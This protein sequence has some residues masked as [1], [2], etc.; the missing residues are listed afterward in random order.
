MKPDSPTEGIRI[1]AQRLPDARPGPAP[2]TD[3]GGDGARRATALGLALAGPV[4]LVG[5]SGMQSALS[6]ASGDARMVATL[7]WW[8]F[9]VATFVLVVSLGLLAVAVGLRRQEERRMSRRQAALLVVGGGVVAPILAI[10]AV[11]ISGVMI[12]DETEG[13]GGADGPVVEVIGERWWWEF[14]YLDEAGRTTAVTANELH[15]PVGRRARLRLISDNVI[16]S[17]WAPNLQG[18]TDLIPGVENVLYAEPDRA[19]EWRGQCAEYCGLQHALM[20]FL[21][22]AQPLAAFETWL[23]AQAR[24]ATVG[25]RGWEVFREQGCDECHTIRGTAAGGTDGPDLTHLASRRTIASATL[26]NTRGNLGGWITSTQHVKPG[27]LMPE[28]APAPADLAALLDFLGE[29]E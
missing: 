17:F 1:T 9:A 18:K 16:H 22:I 24:P 3:G 6:P 26:P 7:S 2:A 11:S 29:L 4:I 25:G 15:L 28:S 10:I 14:R 12:G 21:V 8:M 20:G 5:C 23:A 13:P 19:G 27:A